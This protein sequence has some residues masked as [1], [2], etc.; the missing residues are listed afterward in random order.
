MNPQPTTNI[1]DETYTIAII[2][3]TMLKVKIWMNAVH[4]K[5]N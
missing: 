1:D 3:D 4:L 5:L 2:E